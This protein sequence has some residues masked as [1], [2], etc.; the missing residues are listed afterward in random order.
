MDDR[1]RLTV[2]AL[3]RAVREVD[4]GW[5]ALRITVS[6]KTTNSTAERHTGRKLLSDEPVVIE[7][8]VERHPAG[9][10]AIEPA[11]HCL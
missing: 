1:K 8:K 7:K 5:A 2:S 6:C 11:L 4:T 10:E 3:L 9:P